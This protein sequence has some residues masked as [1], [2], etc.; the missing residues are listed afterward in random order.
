M[1]RHLLAFLWTNNIHS[2]VTVI[3]QMGYLIGLAQSH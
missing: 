2:Y 3:F 1:H